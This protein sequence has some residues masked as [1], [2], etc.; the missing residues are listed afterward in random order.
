MEGRDKKAI[1]LGATGLVGRLLT[2]A[3]L[4]DSRYCEVLIV[5]RT[6]FGGHHPKLREI[7][8]DLLDLDSIKEEFTGDVVF[9]CIGTT[10]AKTPDPK[11]YK[12]I[13]F[14]IPVGAARLCRANK[15]N[16]ILVVSALG[17]NPKSRFFYNRVKGEMEVEVLRLKIPHTYLL[18]PSLIGG[19]RKETRRGERFAQRVMGLFEPLLIGPLKKYR[20]IAPEDISKAMIY[21]AEHPQRGA[22][23]PSDQIKI[24][25]ETI[26][27]MEINEGI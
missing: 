4:E 6:P 27:K 5:G 20:I 8:A 3:L 26:D 1:V 18:Q 19:E 22:R 12:A 2:N 17:A 15:I 23:V 13:D 11:I 9:C 16:T 24:Y 14:G 7:Q 25:A 10:K 21:L